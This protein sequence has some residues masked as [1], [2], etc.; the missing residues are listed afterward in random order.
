[1]SRNFLPGCVSS[2]LWSKFAKL[3]GNTPILYNFLN[4]PCKTRRN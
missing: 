2:A 1:M 4:F 3:S